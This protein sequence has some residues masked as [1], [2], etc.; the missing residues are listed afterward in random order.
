M[1]FVTHLSSIHLVLYGLL[2]YS[3][4]MNTETTIPRYA[5]SHVHMLVGQATV[6]NGDNDGELTLTVRDSD[7]MATT[8]RLALSPDEARNLIEALQGHIAAVEEA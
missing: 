5:P 1:R 3:K 7:D 4:G 2:L 6:A 8:A